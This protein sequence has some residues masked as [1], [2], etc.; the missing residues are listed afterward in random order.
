MPAWKILRR[1]ARCGAGSTYASNGAVGNRHAICKFFR[2]AY[3]HE[4]TLFGHGSTGWL[5]QVHDAG[6]FGWRISFDSTEGCKLQ[7]FNGLLAPGRLA[8]DFGTLV[9]SRSADL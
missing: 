7:R 9:L 4:N 3:R 2:V 5:S 1:P 8:S 6:F